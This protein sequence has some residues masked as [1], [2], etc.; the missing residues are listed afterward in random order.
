MIICMIFVL[1]SMH[2]ISESICRKSLGGLSI[3]IEKSFLILVR[4]HLFGIGKTHA[5]CLVAKEGAK[6]VEVAYHLDKSTTF[7]GGRVHHSS[8]NIILHSRQ[9]V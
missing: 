7:T 6:A 9:P 1:Y 3:K 2:M 8:A 5:N 4:L